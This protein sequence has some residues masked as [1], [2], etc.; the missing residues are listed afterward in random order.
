MFECSAPQRFRFQVSR[1]ASRFANELKGE[2]RLCCGFVA[3]LGN[4][5]LEKGAV[6]ERIRDAE[7]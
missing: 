7:I 5:G 1:N 3:V 2:R 4:V 6:E